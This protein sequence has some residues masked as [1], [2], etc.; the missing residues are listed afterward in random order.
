MSNEKSPKSEIDLRIEFLEKRMN[1]FLD[2]R[3]SPYRP[4]GNLMIDND[5]DD[6]NIE[7]V[8]TLAGMDQVFRSP[9]LPFIS[10]LS[11]KASQT[12]AILHIVM[13]YGGGAKVTAETLEIYTGCSPEEQRLAIEALRQGDREVG[14][15]EGILV[16]IELMTTYMHRKCGRHGLQKV[17]LEGLE[18]FDDVTKGEVLGK[19]CVNYVYDIEQ[20]LS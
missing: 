17:F 18:D 3:G 5:D 10:R 1:E 6:A 11:S 13:Y 8:L 20:A 14:I 19:R 4:P 2:S 16:S 12:A 15:A 7:A 9:W